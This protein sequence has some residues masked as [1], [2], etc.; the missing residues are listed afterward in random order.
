MM[1][2]DFIR[3]LGMLEIA[4]N[5]FLSD[6]ELT[7]RTSRSG[8]PGGQNVNK[9]NTRVAVLF[10]VAGSPSLSQ[11]QKQRILRT[12]AQ[13]ID[14]GGVLRVVSQKYRSQEANRRAAVERLQQLLRDVL[15]P[16]PVRRKTKVPAGAREHR[17]REKKL[18]SH[19][20]RQR[21]REGW[22]ED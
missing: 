11:E 12:L 5:T 15:R 19:L 13:R 18:R 6:E 16:V 7:F 17:L 20:K 3:G 22:H 8:G 10:D 2:P 21:A 14:K 4:E 9:L 1:K